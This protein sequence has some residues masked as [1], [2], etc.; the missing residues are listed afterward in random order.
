MSKLKLISGK[1]KR[2]FKP[3]YDNYLNALIRIC[4]RLVK[5]PEQVFNNEKDKILFLLIKTIGLSS[6]K[7]RDMSEKEI[8]EI[9]E[10]MQLVNEIIAQHTP[11]EFMQMFP[12]SK[13]YD[14][15]KYGWK[16]DYFY[17][18]ES[19]KQNGIDEPIGEDVFSFLWDYMN[20]DTEF[21]L[22]AMTSI[23]SAMSVLSG[24][25][26]PTLDFLSEIGVDTYTHYEDEGIMV[27]NCT[28][29]AVKVSKTKR[30]IP[31]YLKVVGEE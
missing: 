22:V 18:I 7:I 8:Y 12:I 9:Y 21:Y 2:N 10:R 28:G 20:C 5:D 23:I 29:E 14:G 3:T 1:K 15:K 19:I 17:C 26:D 16:K 6:C 4:E 27:N 13:E 31:K 30:R 11:R 25:S 24:G